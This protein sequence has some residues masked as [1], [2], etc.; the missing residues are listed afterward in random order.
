MYLLFSFLKKPS[1][2]HI[3]KILFE[4]TIVKKKKKRRKKEKHDYDFGM[5]EWAE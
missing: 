4:N 5:Y 2:F 1:T 3:I